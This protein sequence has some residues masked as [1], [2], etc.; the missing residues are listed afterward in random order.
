MYPES[1]MN[2]EIT[3][4]ELHALQ[5]RGVAENSRKLCLVDIREPWEVEAASLPDS[6]VIPM[7]EFPSRAHQELDPEAHIIVYCHNGRRSLG[8]TLWLREEGFPY[9]QSLAGG[10][11]V[12]A[13][14]I[15]PSV[16][17]Y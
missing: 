16:P 10:I 9:S 14:A 3:V 2:H 8:V 13:Q 6:L 12:W 4:Q 5:Q 17:R 1:A 11:E 7:G 15:D